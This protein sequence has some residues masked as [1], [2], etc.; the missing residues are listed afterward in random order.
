MVLVPLARWNG[1]ADTTAFFLTG[2]AFFAP[3]E[4]KG[5]VPDFFL[6]LAAKISDR[7]LA[8]GFTTGVFLATGAGVG[9]E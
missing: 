3:N 7:L 5:D 2:A 6:F 9:A 4:A 1:L 8:K